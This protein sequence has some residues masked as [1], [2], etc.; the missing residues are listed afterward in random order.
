MDVYLY[1]RVG[2][3]KVVA[4][5][6]RANQPWTV[7]TGGLARLFVGEITVFESL[8]SSC[9][10]TGVQ[11]RILSTVLE[12]ATDLAARVSGSQVREEGESSAFSA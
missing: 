3:Q 5:L 1:L 4:N 8:G 10:A 12:E 7:L 2:T 9:W 11:R 6:G